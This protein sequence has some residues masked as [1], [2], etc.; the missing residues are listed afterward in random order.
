MIQLTS[1]SVITSFI[2][3]TMNVL[4]NRILRSSPSPLQQTMSISSKSNQEQ[5]F[6][7]KTTKKLLTPVWRL[8][9]PLKMIFKRKN[10]SL[11]LIKK[12]ENSLLELVKIK[13]KN[14]LS[15]ELVK[16]RNDL[17]LELI[18]EKKKNTELL[19]ENTDLY[20]QL[21]A[22]Y[23]KLSVEK[24]KVSGQKDKVLL[25]KAKVLAEMTVCLDLKKQLVKVQ[26]D[27][28]ERIR[29]LLRAGK[30]FNLKGALEF[31]SFHITVRISVFEICLYHF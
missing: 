4:R 29:S 8:F 31:I 5:N 12:R 25:E 30:M 16:E 19:M 13:E 3:R 21:L 27:S 9:D 14:S 22:L 17:A 26:Y 18:K 10:L 20:K 23:K 2:I 15:L 24:N 1:I 11:E 6:H 7:R 28:Q